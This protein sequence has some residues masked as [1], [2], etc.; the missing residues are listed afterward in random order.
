MLSKL[1]LLKDRVIADDVTRDSAIMTA[2]TLLAGL[3]N[4]LY[5]LSMGILL[6]AEQYGILFS[7]TSLLLIIMVFSQTITIAL[8]KFSS[9]FK[10]EGRLGGVNYL[11]RFSLKRTFLIGIVT[12][13]L[14]A[15]LSPLIS[16]FLNID[17][18]FY[19]VILFS[20]MLGVL[21]LS[22]NSGVLQGL[23]RFLPLGSSQVLLGFLKVAL[24][25]LLVYLGLGI[26]GGLSAIPLSYVMVLLF[27]L[28]FLRDLP[29]VGNERVEVAGFRSYT[30]LVMLAIFSLTMLTNVDV[31]L[32][33]HYLSATD[34]AN[35][36]TI[37]VLGR[38]AFYAPAGIAVA[39]FPKT[40]EL[41]DSEGNRRIFLRALLLTLL[42]TSGVLLVYALFSQFIVQFLFGSKYPLV[43]PYV[44][45]YGVAMALFAFALLMMRYLLSINRTKVAYSLLGVVL[46]QLVLIG[47]FH[48]GIT[49]L[50]NIMFI[51]SI[52]CIISMLPLYFSRRRQ[53]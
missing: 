46:A 19:P 42:I 22:V 32:A 40:S 9:T 18:L 7:L 48:S 30:G 37:S 43:A 2:F 51:S 1:T 34:A 24:G 44:F 16:R 8:A 29:R 36:S 27:T 33:K 17:N 26:Y 45:T 53:G 31:V 4:Y 3:F 41:F 14:L 21:P 20:A 5:Q 13:A 11:W 6:P 23:Q 10:A 15:G 39:M 35:Y 28:F 47:F 12:F 52:L 25:A 49:Q 50:V 38:I